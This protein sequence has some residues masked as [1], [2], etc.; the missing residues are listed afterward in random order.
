MAS[1]LARH[2]FSATL[3]CLLVQGDITAEYVD[4]IVNAANSRLQ[5]GGGIAGAIVR[6]G[7]SAIQEES[8]AWVRAH[9]EVAHAHPAVTGAGSLP[10]RAV[11]HAVGPVWGAGDEEKKLRAAVMGALA[12]A[13]ARGFASIAVPAVSTGV[14]GFP[15]ARAAAVILQ[16][17]ADFA[18][19]HPA[20]SLEEI[21][22]TILDDPTLAV[23][24]EEFN[25]RWK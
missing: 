20:S 21:R 3:S 14:F 23:F 12:E 22:V 5:H 11:I 13:D 10:C 17:V 8:D 15:K 7:G 4:A 16:A 1:I 2:D 19:G 18:A 25:N 9:G 6:R 24:R